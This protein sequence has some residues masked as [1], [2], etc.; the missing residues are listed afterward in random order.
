MG[1]KTAACRGQR[2]HVSRWDRTV[3][4]DQGCSHPYRQPS[5]AGLHAALSR[6]DGC[7][8]R[9]SGIVRV[10]PAEHQRQ[11]RTLGTSQY[12]RRSARTMSMGAGIKGARER[13]SHS[14]R[15]ARGYEKGEVEDGAATVTLGATND[16]V[17]EVTRPAAY[18]PRDPME[19]RS[20][21]ETRG[22]I[23]AYSALSNPFPTSPTISVTRLWHFLLRDVAYQSSKS[24][25][26]L[27]AP[28]EGRRISHIRAQIESWPIRSNAFVP[29][30]HMGQ[31]S[32]EKG[33]KSSQ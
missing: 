8:H 15:G 16:I 7:Q 12:V 14:K 6:V 2:Q 28:L 13:Q 21:T 31:C 20:D 26:E 33:P 23:G 18:A 27:P 17:G 3:L 30:G 4:S 22:A 32:S 25:L 10:G 24:R 5:T 11:V 9:P 29:P 1:W 19:A